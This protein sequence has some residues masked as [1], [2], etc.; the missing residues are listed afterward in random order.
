MLVGGGRGVRGVRGVGAWAWDLGLEVE[1]GV[2]V[3]GGVR[4]RV[5]LA[6]VSDFF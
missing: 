2:P 1:A 4:V 3:G 6:D 5:G